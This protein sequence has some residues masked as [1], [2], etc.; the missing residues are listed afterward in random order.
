MCGIAGWIDWQADLSG[1]SAILEGM[2]ES[3]VPRGPDSEGIWTSPHAG[4]AHRR[5]AVVDPEGGAQPMSRTYDNETYTMVYNGELYNTDDLRNELLERGYRFFTT[6][7]TEVLL[8]SYIEWGDECLEKL[9]GIYAFAIWSHKAE[10][11]FLARD[12]LG[13]KPLFYTQQGSSFIFGSEIKALLAHPAVKPEISKEGLC[14]I[15]GLG[16]ART[17]GHGIFNNVFELLPA[18]YLLHTRHGMKTKRYWSL[19]SHTHADNLETTIATIRHLLSDSITRQLV[20]DVPVCTL[21]SGGLDSSAISAFA[22]QAFRERGMGPLHTFSIDYVDNDVYF[23]PNEFQPN[24]DAPWAK[25]VSEHIGSIHHNIYFDTPHLIESL[26]AALHARDLPGMTDIDGSLYLFCGEIKKKATVALSGECADEVFGGYPWFHREEALSATIFPWARNLKEKMKFFS[27]ALHAEVNLEAY[28][29]GRYEEA[30]DEVPRLPG[31][32]GHAARIR[33]M[34]YLNLTRWMP[35]LLDRKDRMSM[36][37]G[38]EVRVPFCDHRL[39]EYMWNVPWA[40]KTHG[41]REKGILR[42]ALHGVLPNDVL[43]RRKS[44]YPKTHNPSYLAT[45]RDRALAVLNDESSPILPFINV[46]A[47]REFANLDLTSVHMPWFGQLMNVPQ[48]FAYLVQVDMWM[49]NYKITVK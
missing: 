28:V 10:S 36:A 35:T 1:Q 22:A 37:V 40:M 34:F 45:V 48:F 11:V 43:M 46:K 25:R 2:A 17:P 18:S 33:E 24:A 9:N 8:V 7:D 26:P 49:R 23:K 39:V 4:F 16:P 47:V 13:V 44:P 27:S 29:K 20:A 32:E 5:L 6:S 31:E 42:Q 19:E 12:R 41:E 38:L 30:L 3:L 15:F 14:E 21:L